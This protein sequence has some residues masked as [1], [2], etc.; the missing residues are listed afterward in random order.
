MRIT[1]RIYIVGGGVW[2]GFGL[3][4]GPDCNVYIV[5]CGASLTL[6]DCGSGMAASVE[7][8]LNN[9]EADGLSPDRIDTILIT[10]KHGDHIGG[11]ADLARRTGARVLASGETAAVLAEGDEQTSSI[12]AAKVAGMYPKDLR[13]ASVDGIEVLEDR[14]CFE[15]GDCA[16]EVVA[17][18]GHCSGHISF[19]MRADGRTDLL[20]G[21]AI[22]W[23]GRVV[24]QTLPDCDVAAS[25]ASIERLA[26]LGEI[27]G[28]F[29]GHGAFTV[30]GATRHVAAALEHVRG[31]RVPPGL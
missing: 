28:L 3:S 15:V 9:I 4:P 30:A 10:H 12:V 21:D 24:M 7:A 11:A 27:D 26:A 2:G 1:S 16:F 6:I 13:L 22:F 31:L 20:A 5:D 14:Q 18:P 17:T 25:G 19:I 8:I 29:S 23:R